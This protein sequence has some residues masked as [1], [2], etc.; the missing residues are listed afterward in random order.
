MT[1]VSVIVPAYNEERWLGAALAALVRQT[2]RDYEVI[3]VDDGSTDATAEIA[4]RFEV[5]L[6]RT[7]H[8][9]DCLARNVGA[10]VATGEILMFVDA[11]EI[12]AP[13]FVERLAAPL[14]DPAVQATFPGGIRWHNLDDPWARGWLHI[15]RGGPR[16][17][18]PMV[19][20]TNRIVRALRRSRFE[21]V[22]GYPPAGYG[23]DELFSAKVGEA[24][25]AHD[26]RLRY[27]LPEGAGEIFGKAR[28]I[29]RG[30]LFAR[31]RP[32]LWELLPPH[33]WIS[34]LRIARTGHRHAALTRVV[35]DAG[36][37]LGFLES[38]LR[39]RVRN[40]A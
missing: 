36:L 9:G 19:R 37:L 21:E 7:G 13:D 17:T 32:P 28:W 18:D 11:D 22:G 2:H 34:A 31:D 8:R 33:S 10:G 38:R 26:A 29:G 40:V 27:T 23:G 1:R 16:F 3:V 4:E 24:L 25:V 20:D 35:Y 5:T 39:P 30:P 12:V 15:R 14:A 6:L